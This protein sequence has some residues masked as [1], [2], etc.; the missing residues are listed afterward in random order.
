MQELFID[1][2]SDLVL[3]TEA[4]LRV[5]YGELPETKGEVNRIEEAWGRIREQAQTM[6]K[7]KAG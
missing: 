4:Y 2:D 6:K 1:K 5:R 3:I 7:R